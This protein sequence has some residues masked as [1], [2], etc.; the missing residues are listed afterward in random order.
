MDVDDDKRRAEIDV[1]ETKPVS[2]VP[3]AYLEHSPPSDLSVPTDSPASKLTSTRR[4]DANWARAQSPRQH[5]N[6]TV[7]T[8]SMRMNL[9]I[10]TV[11]CAPARFPRGPRVR[12]GRG[13]VERAGK[14]RCEAA[15]E[16]NYAT[17]PATGCC[18]SWRRFSGRCIWRRRTRAGVSLAWMR[19]LL[20]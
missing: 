19:I 20:I 18:Q 10:S 14:R 5:R 6:P 7:E 1:R 17:H 16:E 2:P 13:G 15:Q 4:E 8:Y 12:R 9:Q 3:E 11:R